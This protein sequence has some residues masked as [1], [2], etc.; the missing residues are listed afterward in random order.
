[1]KDKLIYKDFI[2]NVHFSTTDLV[3]YGKLEGI[4]DLVTFEGETVAELKKSFEESVDD[5]IEL[6][7]QVGKNPLKSFKGSFNVRIDPEL[8]SKAFTKASLSG[9]SLNQ[10]VQDAI[11]KEVESL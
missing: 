6:C 3:F 4:N 9:K 1:M 10:F 5:Y 8:H 2:G 11:R 7:K